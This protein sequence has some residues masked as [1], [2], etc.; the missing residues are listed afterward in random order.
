M[1]NI[2]TKNKN[3]PTGKS[4]L[5]FSGGMDSLIMNYL[6]S[7]DILLVLPHGQKYERRE[8][9]A[10][11]RLVKK[12]FIDEKKLI[13][14]NRFNFSSFERDDAIIPNR[15]LYFIGAAT[16]YGENIY[17]GSVYGDRSLDK[18]KE[19]FTKCEDMFNYLFQSQHWC[20]ERKFT[21][22]APFK[23]YTKTEL[24]KEF[25][26]KGGNDEMLKVSYSCYNQLAL[27]C[28]KCKPCFRKWVSLEN[29]L[30]KTDDYFL[31]KPQNVDWLDNLLP[32]IQKGEYRGR[33]DKDILRALQK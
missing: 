33:E 4:V 13:Y 1:V 22:S 12:G 23:E 19:F 3:E 6:L 10:I 28:G 8:L 21:I 32:L 2:E 26:S 7:P 5:L 27:P 15:N 17:L 16:D 11:E 29:N 25:L 30:I 18:S 9:E 31:H 14:D 24:V 20:N